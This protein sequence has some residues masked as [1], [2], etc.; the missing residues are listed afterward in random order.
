MAVGMLA[1]C[2]KYKILILNLQVSRLGAPARANALAQSRVDGHCQELVRP[3]D[4][5][6]SEHELT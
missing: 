3:T 4:K 2:S 1:I 6:A 5:K